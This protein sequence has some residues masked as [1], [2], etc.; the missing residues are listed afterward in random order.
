MMNNSLLN[1]QPGSN[2][3]LPTL[4]SECSEKS[5][6]WTCQFHRL[7]LK[8]CDVMWCDGIKFWQM[9]LESWDG[10][11][12]IRTTVTYISDPISRPLYSKHVEMYLKQQARLQT[13]I[14]FWTI[15]PFRLLHPLVCYW[16]KTESVFCNLWSTHPWCSMRYQMLLSPSSHVF[17]LRRQLFDLFT[18]THPSKMSLDSLQFLHLSSEWVLL[19]WH[20]S[21]A[22]LTLMALGEKYNLWQSTAQLPRIN[23]YLSK[24]YSYGY[25]L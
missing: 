10:C 15:L 23:I 12:F 20:Y 24:N 25:S 1:P 4:E 22:A 7:R 11:R 5:Q 3:V 2:L 21:K 14:I 18:A 17:L 19:A 6:V 13:N 16:T 9:H 8:W